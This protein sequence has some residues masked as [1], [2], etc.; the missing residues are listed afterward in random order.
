MLGVCRLFV[1]CGAFSIIMN[2][3]VSAQN[4]PNKPIHM[5]L[6]FPAGAP[7][8]IVGRGISQKLTEQLGVNVITDNRVSAGGNLGIAMVAKSPPDG[9]TIMTTSP[10][11]ALSPVLYNQLGY[12]PQKDLTPIVR[13]AQ[14]E[15][16]MLVHPS[17]PVRTL[18]EFIS[19]ARREPG[20]LNYGSGG[21]GTTNHLANE[22]LKT[23]EN[24]NLVHVPY[25]GATVAIISLIGGEVDEVVV[26]VASSLPQI[27]AGKVRPIVVLSE[28]RVSTLPDVPTAAEA[29]VPA[30]QMS[31]WFGI[32][33]PA[34]LPRDIISKLHQE[35]VKALA[36][37]DL[38]Q[39]FAKA[40]V[41]PWPGTPE[42]MDQLIRSETA[43]YA[44]IA[45]K[46]GLKKE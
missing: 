8:D 35:S 29:G 45:Q 9:Y 42:Q 30:F 44:S 37:A 15:N 41:D 1:V 34:R 26:S 4:Y 27:K 43:R 24:I 25:K 11:I 36:S 6:P 28:K 5:I 31:I 40:G 3:Q 2:A 13:L 12:D 10:S 17:V 38:R 14:I 16:V 23:I 20:R 32:L 33:G 7:S 22:L 18:R 21:M 19:L 46:A 39:H